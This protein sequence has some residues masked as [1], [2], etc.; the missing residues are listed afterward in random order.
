MSQVFFDLDGVLR[1]L[2]LPILGEDAPSWDYVHE[3]RGI[4]QHI[5][6]NCTSTDFDMSLEDLERID[7][8]FLYKSYWIK[9]SDI[10]PFSTGDNNLNTDVYKS[11]A[12]ALENKFQLTPSP[13]ALS[14]ELKI[15]K[16]LSKP[17][18]IRIEGDKKLLVGGNIRYWGWVLAFGMDSEIECIIIK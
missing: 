10:T 16:Q 7:S 15:I 13:F 8:T 11:V 14:E 4:L 1:D 17:V 5:E 2:C 12:D 9:C 18:R 6:D 3:G